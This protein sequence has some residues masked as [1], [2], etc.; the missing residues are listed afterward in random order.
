MPYS[1]HSNVIYKFLCGISNATYYSKTCQHLIIRVGEHLGV[2]P[3]TGKKSKPKKSAAVKDHIMLFCDHIVSI[4]DFKIL[5]TSDS[6]F[7][8]KVEE[9][10]LV[11]R[12]EPILNKN[13]T[14]LPL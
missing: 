14:L 6:G 10:L 13:E 11:S 7:H 5:A 2:S 3:L 1:L 9:S 4:D 12:D 8:V